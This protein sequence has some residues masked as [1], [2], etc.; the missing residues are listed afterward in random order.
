LEG[1]D[2]TKGGELM[3]KLMQFALVAILAA[4]TIYAT[5]LYAGNGSDAVSA[6]ATS[7]TESATKAEESPKNA[8]CPAQCSGCPDY[9][10]ANKDN[11]CD[12][13]DVCHTGRAHQGCS[14]KPGFGC[15]R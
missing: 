7:T 2:E 1:K 9:A 4:S 13:R 8:N 3:K 5:R 15:H 6:K 11:R 10:D 12:K 14:A